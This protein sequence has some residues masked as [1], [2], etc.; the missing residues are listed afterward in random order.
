MI[1]PISD[2]WVESKTRMADKHLKVFLIW[3][4]SVLYLKVEIYDLELLTF[5]FEKIVKIS[6]DWKKDI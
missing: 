3:G 5:V 1:S 2:M 4:L 6:G